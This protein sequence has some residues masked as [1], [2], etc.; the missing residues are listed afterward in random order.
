[1]SARIE[2]LS[3]RRNGGARHDLAPV[4]DALRQ[5]REVTHNI[6]QEKKVRELPSPAAISDVLDGLLTVLFPTHLGPHGLKHD[7]VDLFVANTLA[8]T[9][10]RLTDQIARGLLFNAES[11]SPQQAQRSAE[12]IVHRFAHELPTIRAALVGDLKEIRLKDPAAESLGEILLCDRGFAA[13]FHR[14]VANVLHHHGA[15][16]VARFITRQAQSFSKG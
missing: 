7:S 3:A 15:R 12:E 6:R 14:R 11:L 16:L 10:T 9:L 4:V 5:S 2:S 8:T 1:M 13:T